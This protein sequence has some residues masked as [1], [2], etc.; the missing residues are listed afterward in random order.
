[1]SKTTN[2]CLFYSFILLLSG[3]IRDE[4]LLPPVVTSFSSDEVPSGGL[5]TIIGDNFDA[6]GTEVLFGTTGVIASSVAK[7]ELK[8]IVPMTPTKLFIDLTVRTKYGISPLK[9]IVVLPPLPVVTKLIPAAAG[10]GKKIKVVG[11]NFKDAKTISFQSPGKEVIAVN[12]VKLHDDTL[13][14]VIPTGL[15]KGA[16]GLQ[17]VTASGTSIIP[18]AFTVLYPPRLISFTPSA[19]A[20]GQSVRIDGEDL[21]NVFHVRIGPVTADIL[22]ATET[23]LSIRVPAGASNDTIFAESNAGIGKTATTFRL[24]PLPLISSLD[25][26]SAA[27]GAE[28]KITGENFQSVLGVSFAGSAAE[29]T[30]GTD[31]KMITAIVPAGAKSGKVSV[32]TAAGTTESAQSFSVG[33]MFVIS[34]FTPVSGLP[35]TVIKAKGFSLKD[36]SSAVIGGVELTIIQPQTDTLIQL[37]VRPG[38]ATGFI[39]ATGAASSFTT[40]V[41][42]EVPGSA[43]ITSVS[44]SSGMP[45]TIVTITGTS[46]GLAPVVRFTGDAIASIS[47]ASDTKIVCPVPDGATS[48]FV[49]V[50]GAQSSNQ[51][52]LLVKPVVNGFTPLKGMQ[53]TTEITIKGKY[54]LNSSVSFNGTAAT[55][56]YAKTTD[57]ELVV[58]VPAGA[59]SGPIKVSN[60]PGNETTTSQAFTIVLPP[61]ITNITP[62][63][64][65]PGSAITITGQN[66][67]NPLVRF[68]NGVTTEPNT[69]STATQLNVVVPAGASGSGQI[70]LISESGTI[71]GGAF[72][73]VKPEIT[74]ELSPLNLTPGSTLTITGKD[75]EVVNKVNIEGVLVNTPFKS[76]SSV[77]LEVI[78]PNNASIAALVNRVVNVS[79]QYGAGFSSNSKTATLLGLP[80]ITKISPANNPKGW[81]IL[82][83]GTNLGA[84]TRIEIDGKVPEFTNAGAGIDSKNYSYLVSKIPNTATA[85]AKTIMLTYSDTQAPLPWAYTIAANAPQG[86]FPPPT[87]L[88]PPPVPLSYVQGNLNAY[89]KNPHA[90]GPLHCF[91]IRADAS[92]ITDDSQHYTTGT[93][94]FNRVDEYNKENI[95]DY[96]V[97]DVSHWSGSWDNGYL[98]LIS[99]SGEI[100]SGQ[101]SNGQIILTSSTRGY[102]L[103]L[104]QSS[105][106]EASY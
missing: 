83:E 61:V 90:T 15:S 46:F 63:F 67:T 65:I 80:T 92:V 26:L 69:G 23:T 9:K 93:G 38:T 47:R 13:T 98:T 84:I 7:T 52:A 51:F 40:D 78:V 2:R 50:N 32:S 54:L 75:L 30:A 24:L 74:T 76:Q 1:M 35:G 59:T 85:G 99:P 106:C 73:V 70:T 97:D 101:I 49:Y 20:V 14:V 16:A 53:A 94:A 79:V 86:V 8:V 18:A 21:L 34:S 68:A 6:Q 28:V 56:P 48:G 102:Q 71:S 41:A 104:V 12:A 36:V 64:A 25:K 45:G 37:Q 89:W 39:T 4:I 60:G 81:A 55:K 105:D 87:I 95:E 91:N 43:V 11:I 17:V 27:A 22:S 72:R 88:L 44:P 5:L 57:T 29:F 96:F 77:K 66:F 10:I 62:A 42:F 3:C 31:G 19:G 100:W 82:I 103:Q 58:K 33:G